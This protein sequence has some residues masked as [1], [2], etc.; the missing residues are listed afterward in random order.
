M[1]TPFGDT[2]SSKSA[3]GDTPVT[4]AEPLNWSRRKD[5]V[6]PVSIKNINDNSNRT[7]N[8]NRN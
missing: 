3:L 5:P 1:L 4:A 8:N 2:T 7:N 6:D